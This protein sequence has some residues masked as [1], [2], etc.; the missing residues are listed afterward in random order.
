MPFNIQSSV[1]TPFLKHMSTVSVRGVGKEGAQWMVYGVTWRGR[2]SSSYKQDWQPFPVD[3]QLAERNDSIHIHSGY[4]GPLATAFKQHRWLSLSLFFFDELII[5]ELISYLVYR[6]NSKK[7]VTGPSRAPTIRPYVPMSKQGTQ[8]TCDR[9]RNTPIYGHAH[10]LGVH[11]Y[12]T[13][14]RSPSVGILK[15]TAVVA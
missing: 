2:R 11:L 1:I 7:Q 13:S 10:R 8:Q 14:T 15:N 4:L 6:Q 3:T 9:Y 5:F 12:I